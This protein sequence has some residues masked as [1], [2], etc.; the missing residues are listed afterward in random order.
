MEIIKINPD[1]CIGCGSCEA[2]AP[3][4]FTINDEGIAEVV[5]RF[6]NFDI[7]NLDSYDSIIDA[8]ENCPTN[9]IKKEEN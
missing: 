5:T 2:I 3:D 7:K 9:A 1:A 8:V 4:M 6:V